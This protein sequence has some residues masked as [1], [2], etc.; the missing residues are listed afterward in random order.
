M[1]EQVR[2]GERTV[3]TDDHGPRDEETAN[4]KA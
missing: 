1:R 4:I 3:W 2:L